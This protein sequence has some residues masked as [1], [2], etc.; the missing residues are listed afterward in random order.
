MKP[1]D[2]IDLD[3]CVMKALTLFE[4]ERP[5]KVT[6]PFKRPLIVGSGNAAVTGRIM[7]SDMDAVFSDESSFKTKLDAIPEIDGGVLLSAS[8]GKHAPII[9]RELKRRGKRVV[10]LTNNQHA[11]AKE[12]ADETHVFPK[13]PEPYTY[14]TSTY[15]GMILGKTH[16]DPAAIRAH[17]ET[18]HVPDFTPYDAYLII[19]PNEFNE[20][21]EMFLTK[22]DEL[23]GPVISGRVFTE[24]QMKHAKTVVP[25]EKEC[26]IGLGYENTRFGRSRYNFPLPKNAGPVGT[27]ATGYYLIGKI[28]KQ[29][30]PYFKEHIA[31]FTRKAS[32][33]F[34]EE[35]KPWVE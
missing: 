9:A 21:R 3:E 2:F 35:I 5:P 22:F 25:S 17:L 18:L 6:F 4:Q 30:K 8:G 29:N 7:F 23:F 26:F 13:N 11:P 34:G 15:F 24:E 19:V 27:L 16:E 12:V 20:T 14:N 28:Q 33:T 32:E 1:Q 10:L 31:E